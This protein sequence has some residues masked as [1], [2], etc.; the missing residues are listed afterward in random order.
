MLPLIKKRGV[1][2]EAHFFDFP[3]VV[4]KLALGQYDWH[5]VFLRSFN[6]R[7]IGKVMQIIPNKEKCMFTKPSTKKATVNKNNSL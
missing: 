5:Q 6:S 1:F 2:R 3:Q 4:Y 7:M